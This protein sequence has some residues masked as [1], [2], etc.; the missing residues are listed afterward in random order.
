MNGKLLS[1]SFFLLI[2]CL[3]GFSQERYL[4]VENPNQ[5]KRFKIRA[6]ET[7]QYK[8]EGQKGW[9]EDMIKGLTYTHIVVGDNDHIRIENIEKVSL[10]RT[11][12][13]A[14]A[15]S[16]IGGALMIG[17]GGFLGADVINRTINGKGPVFQPKV[18]IITGSMV[19]VGWLTSSILVNKRYKTG[20]KWQLEI[21]EMPLE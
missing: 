4:A 21:R 2:H 16:W 14:R 11:S 9:R 13:G 15:G 10:P 18:T 12:G 6:G 3:T 7:L 19:L 20:D 17:G 1:L 8:I 5:F